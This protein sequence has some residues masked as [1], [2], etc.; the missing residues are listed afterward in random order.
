[1]LPGR[2]QSAGSGDR[3]VAQQADGGLQAGAGTG[4]DGAVVGLG[5]PGPQPGR[6]LGGFG[7][8]VQGRVL[9]EDGGLQLAQPGPRVDAE[10]PGQQGASTAQYRQGVG[11]AS[12]AVQGEGEQPPA[13]LAPGVVGQVRV[14]VGHGLRGPAGR[15]EALRAVFDGAQP[16]FGQP[17]ALAAGPG[18]SLKS[19]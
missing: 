3:Q 19:A 13:L 14:Q 11:L 6:R 5:G 7:R 2:L 4:G 8:R 1:M 10:P 15:D 9:G 16:Q 12:R 17:G 18:A